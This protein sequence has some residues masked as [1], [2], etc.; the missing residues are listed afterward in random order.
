MRGSWAS[1]RSAVRLARSCLDITLTASITLGHNEYIV[2][3]N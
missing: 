3:Y 1:W 2:N